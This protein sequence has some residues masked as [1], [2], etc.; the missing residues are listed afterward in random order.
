MEGGLLRKT[1]DV[2]TQEIPGSLGV[3]CQELKGR[4]Q[5]KKKKNC[6]KTAEFYATYGRK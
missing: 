2:I 5:F 4:G 1:K 6:T 3:L